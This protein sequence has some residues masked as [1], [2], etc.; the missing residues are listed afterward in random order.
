MAGTC[1]GTADI[2]MVTSDSDDGS[3][4]VPLAQRLKRKKENFICAS[5]TVT[6]G[7]EVELSLP[8]NLASSQLP[9]E[10]NFPHLETLFSFHQ[11]GTGSKKASDDLDEAEFLQC[12]LP[13]KP[14]YSDTSPA[15]TKP[16]KRRAEEIQASRVEAKRMGDAMDRRQK[17]KK[18]VRQEDEKEHSEKKA[19]AEAA[20]ALRPD[21]CINHMVVVVDPGNE[22][23]ET[24]I[25]HVIVHGV[26]RFYQHCLII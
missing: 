5:S 7:K 12:L 23:Q 10:E 3:P 20:K 18:A 9:L 14:L 6:N 8:A 21:E 11:R 17:G 13:V 19:L 4:C 26:N 1:L 15:K 16:V 25:I 22:W 2:M 24:Q